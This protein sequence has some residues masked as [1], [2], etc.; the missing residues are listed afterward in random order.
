MTSRKG[1]KRST[2]TLFPRTVHSVISKKK[3]YH[4]HHY[5]RI[6]DLDKAY[7]CRH[8]GNLSLVGEAPMSQPL[9]YICVHRTKY[10][11][12]L[13]ALHPDCFF[14]SLCIVQLSITMKNSSSCK[15]GNIPRRGMSFCAL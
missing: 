5:Q 11:Y 13:L 1:L 2:G 10:L 8:V 3:P 15:A 14:T 6:S 9:M 12:V 7:H 4:K